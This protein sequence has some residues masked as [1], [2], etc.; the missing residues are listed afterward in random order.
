MF[1]WLAQNERERERALPN[2]A[3]NLPV[4]GSPRADPVGRVSINPHYRPTVAVVFAL[5]NERREQSGFRNKALALLLKPT[6][7]RAVRR[8]VNNF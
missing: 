5:S 8:K 6:P 7:T 1:G 4:K 3:I 2:E